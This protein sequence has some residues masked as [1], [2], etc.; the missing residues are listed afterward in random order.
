[1]TR[2]SNP[3]ARKISARAINRFRGVTDPSLGPTI[4][5]QFVG[6]SE[7]MVSDRVRRLETRSG[8]ERGDI[9]E[10]DLI[11]VKNTTGARTFAHGPSISY[12]PLFADPIVPLENLIFFGQF[13]TFQPRSWS[14][15]EFPY[16]LINDIEPFALPGLI[17]EF[18]LDPLE[19]FPFDEVEVLIDLVEEE[20]GLLPSPDLQV[21]PLIPITFTTFGSA[22]LLVTPGGM[23]FIETN[24]VSPCPE[25]IRPK[26]GDFI[27]LTSA[28]SNS[29]PSATKLEDDDLA[30]DVTVENQA[31]PINTI[32]FGQFIGKNS[33]VAND[34][35]GSFGMIDTIALKEVTLRGI[36]LRHGS[37]NTF[38]NGDLFTVSHPFP[39]MGIHTAAASST[40]QLIDSDP[41]AGSIVDLLLA[42]DENSLIYNISDGS[43]GTIE[44]ATLTGGTLTVNLVGPLAGGVNN[45]FQQNDVYAIDIPQQNILTISNLGN[46]PISIGVIVVEDDVEFTDIPEV[47]GATN[48]NIPWL[49]IFPER[50]TVKTFQG[51]GTT[52]HQ[53]LL[54]GT[55]RRYTFS[56][57]PDKLPAGTLNK[58]ASIFVVVGTAVSVSAIIKVP[59]KVKILNI[60]TQVFFAEKAT[61]SFGAN[62]IGEGGFR[63]EWTGT[64]WRLF[65]IGRNFARIPLVCNPGLAKRVTLWNN[66]TDDPPGYSPFGIIFDYTVKG[67]DGLIREVRNA[68]GVRGNYQCNTENNLIASNNAHSRFIGTSSFVLNY[69]LDAFNFCGQYVRIRFINFGFEDGTKNFLWVHEQDG[70][71]WW[72]PEPPPRHTN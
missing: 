6:T 24:V 31:G 34:T 18:E 25:F 11:F 4:A 67:T 38:E 15:W 71:G 72:D 14:L 36:G 63:A 58:D 57:D 65:G 48:H 7:N 44:T 45:E 68:L 54:S 53:N 41:N 16:W 27:K 39:I 56:V 21:D 60:E 23:N 1:M 32:G 20:A 61:T 33:L 8:Q 9:F 46:R 40:A 69:T 12:I 10:G 5:E 51:R 52:L 22:E 30:Q 55:T 29:V 62:T 42:D 70:N 59:I 13:P 66:T 43:T 26:M 2:V 35:D 3:N 17:I 47:G 49:T 19:E 37:D 28:A 50:S 64:A